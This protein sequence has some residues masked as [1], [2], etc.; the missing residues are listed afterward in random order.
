MPEKE[1]QVYEWAEFNLPAELV[2][3]PAALSPLAQRLRMA[4]R[5][6]NFHGG[7]A[8]KP[9]GSMLLSAFLLRS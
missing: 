5:A 1:K 7:Q 4:P 9:M 2:V 6:S 3:G 8:A